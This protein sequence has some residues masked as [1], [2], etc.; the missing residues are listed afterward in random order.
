MKQDGE[1]LTESDKAGIYG[2]FQRL[3][4]ESKV[5]VGLHTLGDMVAKAQYDKSQKHR[6]DRPKLREEIDKTALAG[7]HR[8]IPSF[9]YG[10]GVPIDAYLTSATINK[11]LNHILAIIPD[12]AEIR[13]QE[14][15]RII[16]E[17]EDNSFDEWD[18]CISV[19]P[20][21]NRVIYSDYWQALKGE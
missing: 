3:R 7:L 16:K 9:S 10:S 2:R 11:I 18:G 17:V 8:V 6:L 4:E 12:E 13:K 21:K 20:K 1:K 5:P 14:R 19:E 15:E